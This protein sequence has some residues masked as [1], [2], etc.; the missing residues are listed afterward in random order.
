MIQTIT[1][2]IS[3]VAGAIISRWHGGGI[4]KSPKF[5][6]NTI[7]A[8][9]FGIAA[10]FVTGSFWLA[11]LSFALCLAGKATGHGGFMDLGTWTKQRSR[12]ALEFLIKPLHDKI[13]ESY[14]DALG[15]SVVGL[16]AVSGGV[17]AFAAVSPIAAL[18]L[19][20]GGVLKSGAYMVAKEFVFAH[21]EFTPYGE[22]LSG[23]FAYVTLAIATIS[24]LL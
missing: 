4:F 15:L 20:I 9:P 5:I 8:A 11:A 18:I 24:V 10:F 7:W 19:A 16:A 3:G 21:E 17:L 13:P 6:K 2:F 14:Y 1:L 12:E 23:A 22:A